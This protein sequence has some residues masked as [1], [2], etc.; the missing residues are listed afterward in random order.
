M[1]PRAEQDQR[2]IILA[3]ADIWQDLEDRGDLDDV[4][5]KKYTGETGGVPEAGI[6]PE[7]TFDE[8]EVKGIIRFITSEELL[9]GGGLYKHNDMTFLLKSVTYVTEL[10]SKDVVVYDE[11]DY[12]CV[13][14]V[15]PSTIDGTIYF[16][17]TARRM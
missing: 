12:Q 1:R 3:E 2:R 11:N 14:D 5:I 4:T 8:Y 9:A 7:F 10:N 16:K 17:F 6:E 15:V 13:G